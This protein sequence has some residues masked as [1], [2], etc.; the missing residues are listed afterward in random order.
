MLRATPLLHPLLFSFIIILLLLNSAIFIF[1]FGAPSSERASFI[2]PRLDNNDGDENILIRGVDE[3]SR[4][5]TDLPAFLP[6]SSLSSCRRSLIHHV[7]S[8]SMGTFTASSLLTATTTSSQFAHHY[9]IHYDCCSYSLSRYK[10]RGKN[11]LRL[12]LPQ[13][14]PAHALDAK[15][16]PNLGSSSF[17]DKP[18]N[19]CLDRFFSYSMS[20]G[21]EDYEAKAYP[22]KGR[23]FDKMLHYVSSRNVVPDKKYQRPTILEIGMGTFPNAT[24]YA[25]ALRG[26]S[27]SPISINAPDGMSLFKQGLDIISLDPNDYMFDYAKDSAKKSGLLS[28][29]SS[30]SLTTSLRNIHGVAEALPFEDNT[31]DAVVGT[32]TL[33][34]VTNQQVALNEIQ[35]VL[36]PKTGVYLFWEHVLSEKDDGLA[37]QQRFLSPLQR[38]VADGC[39]LDRRTGWNIE[40]AGFRGG[41]EMEYVML[42]LGR[43]ASII[44]PTVLGLAYA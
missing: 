4:K 1:A 17:Y 8:V 30:S 35:R 42:D 25:R 33:C 44:S 23:L 21:M 39:H 19:S 28:S 40:H 13:P 37:F 2:G 36:K 9:P 24:Y 15:T 20:T 27:I 32:L 5:E 31:L 11:T 22:Y 29:S 41:V 38:I 3:T 43:G 6:S 18:R 7:A 26:T 12:S 14:P 16:V 10:S 34:S